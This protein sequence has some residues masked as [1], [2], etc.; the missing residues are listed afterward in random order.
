DD[1][2]KWIKVRISFTDNAGNQ[3]VVESFEVGPV[4]TNKSDGNLRLV[5]L[6]GASAAQSS[7]EGLLQIFDDTSKR[8]RGVCD[9][10]WDRKDADVTCRQLGYTGSAEALTG[11]V[12]FGYP[13]LLF[14]LD[15]V[16]CGGTENTLLEC[17]HA[18]RG[19]HDCTSW[20]YAGVKCATSGN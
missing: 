9:D 19:V 12:W 20:E 7:A 4:Y 3:E 17:E 10:S 6:P 14:M 16:N 13:P 15:E 18:G 1:E 11:I 8:W 2:E 5:S